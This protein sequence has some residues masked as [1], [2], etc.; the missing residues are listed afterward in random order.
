MVGWALILE[1]AV[2]AS[3]VSVGWS[4]YF[5]G[6]LKSIT[7]LELP[8]ALSAGPVWRMNGLVP[9]ADV[10]H[11]LI[12]IPAIVI[13][14]AVTTHTGRSEDRRVGKEVVSKWRS[15]GGA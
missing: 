14:L 12:N 8:Q 1:Y 4:G 5:M 6:L 15:W 3:A 10:T 13:D 7:G 11:G 9:H 2:A